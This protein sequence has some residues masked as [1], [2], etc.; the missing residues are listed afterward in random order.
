MPANNKTSVFRYKLLYSPRVWIENRCH[1]LIACAYYPW[2]TISP[3]YKTIRAV[4]NTC[5]PTFWRNQCTCMEK[6]LCVWANRN[7][8]LINYKIRVASVIYLYWDTMP[9]YLLEVRNLY[10][11]IKRN[12]MLFF[13]RLSS[14]LWTFFVNEIYFSFVIGNKSTCPSYAVA[15]SLIIKCAS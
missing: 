13:F 9:I 6:C 4:V 1:T 5:P 10:E 8:L 7:F 3:N 11:S 15:I 14:V 2:S 12:F